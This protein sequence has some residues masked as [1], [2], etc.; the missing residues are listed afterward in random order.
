MTVITGKIGSGKTVAMLKHCYRNHLAILANSQQEQV[1][2]ID[3]AKQLGLN[4]TV[5]SYDG[6]LVLA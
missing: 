5:Y 6:E 3:M 2:Y 1:G 4:V